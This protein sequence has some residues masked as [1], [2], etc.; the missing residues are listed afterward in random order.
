VDTFI[1]E[2]GHYMDL[3]VA[4]KKL[5][6]CKGLFG[7]KEISQ[8]ITRI[9]VLGKGSMIKKSSVVCRSILGACVANL[10]GAILGAATSKSQEFIQCKVYLDKFDYPYFI[11]DTKDAYLIASLMHKKQ[12]LE[13]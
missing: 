8:K 6:L 13:E 9:E 2:A 5:Y 11:V 7:M 4:G 1:T 10:P 3:I 12:R